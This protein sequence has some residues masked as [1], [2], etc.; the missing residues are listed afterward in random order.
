[1]ENLVK[2]VVFPDSFSAGV[3]AE[4]Y[5]KTFSQESTH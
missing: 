4:K 2:K 5:G 3:C 1:M